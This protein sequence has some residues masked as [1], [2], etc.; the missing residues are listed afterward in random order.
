MPFPSPDMSHLC[1]THGQVFSNRNLEQ[2]TNLASGKSVDNASSQ[3][4]IAKEHNTSTL[5]N[6]GTSCDDDSNLHSMTYILEQMRI[7]SD[8]YRFFGRSSQLMLVKAATDLKNEYLGQK[9]DSHNIPVQTKRPEFWNIPSV[10]F[11]T[12]Q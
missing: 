10:R 11:I 4:T 3:H 9:P 5:Q 2:L 6:S 8:R 12:I 7:D 1:N